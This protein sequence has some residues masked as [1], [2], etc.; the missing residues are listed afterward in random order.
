MFVKNQLWLCYH[1]IGFEEMVFRG[2][3]GRRVFA[4]SLTSNIYAGFIILILFF[5][6]YTGYAQ[7]KDTDSGK[8]VIH[9]ADS[10]PWGI[11]HFAQGGVVVDGIAYFL[12]DQKFTPNLKAPGFPFGVAFHTETLWKIRT[13]P[14]E[15]TYDSS[16]LVIQRLDGSWLVVAHEYLRQRTVALYRESGEVAWVSPDNQPGAYFFGY[17]Y[18]VR[19]DGSK[20]LLQAATNGLHALSAEDGTE[21]WWIERKTTGGATPCV[22]QD[23]G[24]GYY[25]IDGRMLKIRLADGEVMAETGVGAPNNVVSWNTVL[26][27]DYGSQFIATY[28]FGLTGG[29]GASGMQW[30]AAIRVFDMDLKLVWERTG[31]PA[32]KKSTLTYA[33][34]KL[35]IGAG[36]HLS[37]QYEGEDWKFIIAYDA[38]SGEEV[39]RCDLRQQSFRCIMNVPFAYGCFY[40]EGW[41]DNKG[42]LFRIDGNTGELMETLEYDT[43]V[44]S[45]APPIIA[46]GLMLSGDLRRDGIVVTRLA[47]GSVTDW[48]GP[49]GDPQK[50]TYALPSEPCAKMVPIHEIRVGE[51]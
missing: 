4:I 9:N 45:C 12:A 13:Y 8:R 37:G 2:G 20:L 24:V 14:F 32:P 11:H 30:N 21:V 28:W 6:P 44:S 29:R 31:L 18:F 23:A 27:D 50:N 25:Q 19:K 43:P 39:W 35:V 48:P 36:G 5:L 49:F 33:D 51:K 42:R 38:R 16:P 3:N 1:N 40:A 7:G 41:D 34:G 47:E 26:I 22:D 17:S 46:R 15:D 10:S